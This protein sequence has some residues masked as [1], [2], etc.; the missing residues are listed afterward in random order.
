M[1]EGGGVGKVS[2]EGPEGH[3]EE[4]EGM[5]EEAIREGTGDGFR[6]LDC[7]ES[8]GVEKGAEGK[9]VVDDV[10]PDHG[11][12]QPPS[13]AGATQAAEGV[14]RS[15][16]QR[17]SR[18]PPLEEAEERG[19]EGDSEE[20]ESVDLG[21]GR[22]GGVKG[23][24]VEDCG[25]S[26]AW[27]EVEE[28]SVAS[29]GDQDPMVDGQGGGEERDWAEVGGDLLNLVL[30]GRGSRTL[31]AAAGVCRRWRETAVRDELWGAVYARRFTKLPQERPRHYKH[32]K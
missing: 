24:D 6:D 26:A 25:A 18:Y 16:R 21:G 17:P 15:Q 4:E 14:R 12:S 8:E 10:S 1:G 11:P 22:V 31:L 32:Y 28:G 7:E 9:Q 5:P 29:D 13:A 19:A 20:Q 3:E 30:Q 27:G 2:R 23:L